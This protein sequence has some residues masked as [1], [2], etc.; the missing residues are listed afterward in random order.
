MDRCDIEEKNGKAN[1]IEEIMESMIWSEIETR[2]ASR[3]PMVCKEM[4]GT[5]LISTVWRENNLNG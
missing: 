1:S 2:W 4:C 3:M 5:N